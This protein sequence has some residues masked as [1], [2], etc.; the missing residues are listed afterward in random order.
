V[1]YSSPSDYMTTLSLAT[2]KRECLFEVRS[3]GCRR[4]ILAVARCCCRKTRNFTLV[5][6]RLQDILALVACF[7]PI[8]LSIVSLLGGVG[9][10]NDISLITV[11]NIITPAGPDHRL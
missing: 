6:L 9:S 3:G 4:F 10:L 11:S 7:T 2:E 8:V 1:S 5:M